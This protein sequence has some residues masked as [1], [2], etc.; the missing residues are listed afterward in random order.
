MK[1]PK[2]IQDS[3]TKSANYNAVAKEHNE[4]VRRW[5]EDKGIY[6]ETEDCLIDSIE[7]GCNPKGLIKFIE[8]EKW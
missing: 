4:K 3:I 8:E 7:M 5:L 1:V 2:Y 6:E